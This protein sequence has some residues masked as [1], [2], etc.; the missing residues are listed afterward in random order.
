MVFVL[1]SLPADK[2]EALDLDPLLFVVFDIAIFAAR[3]LLYSED[4][5]P[6]AERFGWFAEAAAVCDP[7]HGGPREMVHWIER[8]ARQA[9]EM[10][11][12]ALLQRPRAG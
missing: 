4:T 9:K 12:L 3:C 10:R 2:R 6:V 7:E 11:L 1:E 8:A 5:R